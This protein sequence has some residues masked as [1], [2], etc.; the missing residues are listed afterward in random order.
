MNTPATLVL[1]FGAGVD[2]NALVVPEFDPVRNIDSSG[3]PKTSFVINED[4]DI[5]FLIHLEAGLQI[6]WIRPTHGSVQDLGMS[7]QLREERCGFSFDD[8]SRYKDLKYFPAE[9]P[10]SFFY[11]NTPVLQ[12]IRGRRLTVDGDNGLPAIAD[13]SYKVDF[14][15]FLFRAPTDVAIREGKTDYP[16]EIRIKIG[17]V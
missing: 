12:P 9:Q 7:C 1:E 15:S 6:E 3:D 5:Y 13:I 2:S 10:A 4:T 16:I 14:H 17:V 8:D 11:G